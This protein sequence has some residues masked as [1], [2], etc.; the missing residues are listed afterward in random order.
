MFRLAGALFAA[1]RLAPP[2]ALVP[3]LAVL[4]L[5][6]GCGG[7]GSSG[8]PVIGA[9]V[10][11]RTAGGQVRGVA[12]QN[13]RLFAG[14]PYA[15]APVGQLRWA[16]PAAAPT[17]SGVRDATRPG[18]RCPQSPVT[19]APS[20]SEDCLYLNVSTPLDTSAAHPVL[21]WIHGG[22]FVGGSG[23]RYDPTRLVT[24]GNL[25]VVTINY[26]LGALGFLAHPA[27]AHDGQVGNFGL[28]D[29][30]AAMRWVHDNIAGFGGDPNRVTLAGESAGAMSVCDQLASPA[31]VGLFQAAII[32]SGPCQAQGNATAAERVSVN[33][34]AALGC[35]D[36]AAAAACLRALPVARLTAPLS[37][38][39]LAGSGLPG[40]VTGG[41]LLPTDPLTAMAN[42]TAAK[43]P[44]L[45]GSTH[46]EFRLFLAQGYQA[47]KRTVSPETYPALVSRTFPAAPSDAVQRRYPLSRFGNSAP[48]AFAAAV[49]DSAFACITGSIGNVMSRTSP[50]YAYEF[51]D[52]NAPMPGGF[53]GTPFPLGAAHSFELPYLFGMSDRELSPAQRQLAD[54][55]VGYWAR[56]VAT[57]NPNSS[58]QPEWP[59]YRP[60]GPVLSLA[61][62]DT[63]VINNFAEEHQ[64]AFWNSTPQK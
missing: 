49:T 53:V 31:A 19:D 55:M 13:H 51:A 9:D 21:L 15:A 32:Q 10:V 11:V 57:G 30:Q 7:P 58:G 18:P 61:S 54:Q 4:M 40:P 50:V 44:V 1:R 24:E 45:L 14:I 2:C 12:A 16:P 64:C 47:T 33:Y 62:N 20:T 28:L 43:V 3:L 59:R 52:P 27:L 26:R 34:A 37:Y 23:D 39:P 5:V 42:G 63:K 25:V 35:P 48:L 36:P 41:A 22:G 56:F 38:Y 17:W 60:D 6:V 46:D 8:V 29:Q